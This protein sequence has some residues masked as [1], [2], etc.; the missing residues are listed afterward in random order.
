MAFLLRVSLPPL[1][2]ASTHPR[3]YL[4]QCALKRALKVTIAVSLFHRF[5]FG[6]GE[7]VVVVEVMISVGATSTSAALV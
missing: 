5:A 6:S 7:T 3:N 4:V 2:A 1:R